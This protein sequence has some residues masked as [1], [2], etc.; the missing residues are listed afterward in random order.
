MAEGAVTNDT[1]AF[2]RAGADIGKLGTAWDDRLGQQAPRRATTRRS[3][4]RYSSA[5]N[6]MKR[7]AAERVASRSGLANALAG[8]W[9]RVSP[10]PVEDTLRALA[11]VDSLLDRYGVVSRDVALSCG[12]EGGLSSVYPVLRTM[13][14]AGELL[15]GEF[16]KGLG[17]AQFA[18][19]E[20]V[21][22]LR[23][24]EDGGDSDMMVLPASDPACVFGR[25]LPW[26]E[27]TGARHADNVAVFA[28]GAPVLFATSRLKS[29]VS[30]TDEACALDEA[31]GALV[32]WEQARIRRKGGSASR[33]KLEAKEFDGKPVLGTEFAELL[34]RHGFV[35]TPDGMRLYVNPF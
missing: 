5:R 23:N 27:A 20:T 28:H 10:A 30:F 35:R 12:I 21:E 33:Q 14:D 15:R 4:G 13:L 1:F 18:S 11:I 31:V 29:L 26:P 24:A 19:R 8:R 25:M 3:H 9:R 17:P 22:Q 6:A 2:V 34:A 32:A 16:V 7:Q